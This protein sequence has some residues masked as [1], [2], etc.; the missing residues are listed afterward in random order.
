MAGAVGHRGTHVLIPEG[1]EN[2]WYWGRAG[3]QASDGIDP[4]YGALHLH[5]QTEPGDWSA[6]LAAI[7]RG[8]GG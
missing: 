6:P 5:R 8:L 7:A 4:W 3:V 1:A 2:M